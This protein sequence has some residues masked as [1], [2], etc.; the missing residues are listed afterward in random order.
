MLVPIFSSAL[1]NTLY[2]SDISDLSIVC[3]HPP[4]PPPLAKNQE[5]DVHRLHVPFD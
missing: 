5:A 1:A 3:V 4:P 2:Y